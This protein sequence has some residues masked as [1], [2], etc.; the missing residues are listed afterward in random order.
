MSTKRIFGITLF[1]ILLIVAVIGV[2]QLSSF[3]RHDS[4]AVRL[5]DTAVSADRAS[6]SEPDA[7]D[8]IEVNRS[9]IQSVVSTLSRPDSFSR[10]VLIESF[11]EGGQAANTISVSVLDGMTSLRILP[12]IG[13]EKRIVVSQDAEYIWYRGDRTPF[14]RSI[15]FSDNN[16]RAADEYQM[17]LTF[18]DILS[19][20]ADEII[21][22]GY[23]P[24]HNGE[25][26]V[27]AVY[28]SRSLGHTRTY[29]ISLE[30]GLIVAAFEYDANGTL[31]YSMTA[32]E[33]FVGEVD[34][35]AFVLPD[36]TNLLLSDH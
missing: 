35:S 13:V 5:P 30:L 6:G 11:W 7:L 16:Q 8:R 28:S 4:D 31:V 1:G 3:M 22:A 29:Y 25:D 21:D 34:P 14:K 18:E 17:L 12:S 27:F 33:T 32:E 20:D 24:Q 19:H 15:S 26:W 2:M 36:G 23:A 9:T 10:I